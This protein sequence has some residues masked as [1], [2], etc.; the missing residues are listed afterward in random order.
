MYTLETQD[1]VM[2]LKCIDKT[3]D[4]EIELAPRHKKDDQQT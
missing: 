2:N 1:A 3:V 4:N